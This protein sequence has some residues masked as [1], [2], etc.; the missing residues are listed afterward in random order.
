MRKLL[1]LSHSWSKD[2]LN[3]DNHLRVKKLKEHLNNLGW[4]CWFDEDDMGISVDASMV[5]GI[6]ESEVFIVCLTKSYCEKINRSSYN[7]RSR[8]NCLKEWN[9]ANARNKFIIGIIME[10]LDLWP[11]GIVTMYLSGLMYINGSGDDILNTAQQL[12]SI[13]IKNNIIKQNPQKRWKLISYPFIIKKKKKFHENLFTNN[14]N[15]RTYRK[16]IKI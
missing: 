15:N 14:N 8:S 13:L 16:I 2:N 9:Y 3:R 10:P 5:K 7:L 1:F 11:R 4:S 6:E 12:N